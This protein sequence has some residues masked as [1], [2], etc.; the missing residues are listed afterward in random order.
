MESP[1]GTLSLRPIYCDESFF[2]R[3]QTP[4]ARSLQQVASMIDAGMETH[5]YFVSHRKFDTHTN[6][7][8]THAQLLATLPQA[9]AAFQSDLENQSLQVQVITMT[10]SNAVGGPLKIMEET[11]IT[12]LLLPYSLWR[13]L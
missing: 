10:F 9:M 8:N 3:L 5:V 6:Q 13:I 11:L 4:L 1:N 12:V 2:R 7:L